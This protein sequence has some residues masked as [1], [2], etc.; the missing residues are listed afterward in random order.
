[1]LQVHQFPCLSDN[2]GFLIR[3]EATGVVACVDTPDAHA[4]ARQLDDL[5]WSLDMILNTHWHPDHVGGN[6][7][8]KARFDCEIIGPAGERDRIPGLDRIVGEG[9]GVQVG[10]S[11]AEVLHTPGH[12]LGHIVYHFVDQQ[13][14]FVGDTLFAMGCGRLFEGTAEQMWDS[15]S[16]LRQWPTETVIYCA[17]E[18]TQA[19]AR[20]ALSVDG[21]NAALRR[22]AEEVDTRRAA[23]EATVPTNLALE[24]ATN[25]FLRAD[26]AGLQLALDMPGAPPASVFAELRRRKDVF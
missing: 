10:E 5:G 19:N 11:Q 3:D 4:I 22:R 8:L 7:A 16:R 14:A 18:Y 6:Q 2:Y 13:L 9:D 21:Q 20:F 26:D 25:P 15:L 17:H 1:M 23:D 12:T 24:C